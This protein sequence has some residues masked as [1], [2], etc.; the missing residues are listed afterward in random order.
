MSPRFASVASLALV[1]G[2]SAVAPSAHASIVGS[3]AG[4]SVIAAPADARLN[5]LTSLTVA[6]AWDEQQDALLPANLRIDAFAPGAYA[7]QASLVNA[8][9]PAG[10]RV[11]SHYVHF[12][13]PAG[14]AASISGSVTFSTPIIGVIVQGDAQ[15]VNWLDRSDFL[16]SGTLYDDA[17]AFRGLEMDSA[18]SF[19]ISPDGLTLSF[20]FAIT[21]PGDR[22]RVITEVP[23][24]GAAAALGLAGLLVTRRRRN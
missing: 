17:L 20:T 24:P 15:L 1:A 23:A 11:A 12:D 13:T 7:S 14:A 16:S 6:H 19:A 5:A 21:E 2:L 18:D 8:F 4:V 3:S 10:T 22:L 9:I